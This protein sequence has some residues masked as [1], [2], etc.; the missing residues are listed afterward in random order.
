MALKEPEQ[1]TFKK[2]ILQ[3]SKCLR[4]SEV[5]MEAYGQCTL[6]P[7]GS[8]PALWEGGLRVLLCKFRGNPASSMDFSGLVGSRLG[9]SGCPPKVK[10]P[11]L[12]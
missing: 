2:I 10:G 11:R 6:D 4:P 3:I 9:T 5:G 7:G 1:E 8:P 12:G